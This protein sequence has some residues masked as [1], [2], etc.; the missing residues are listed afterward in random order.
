M[1]GDQRNQAQGGASA[2]L[3]GS[4][5]DVPKARLVCIEAPQLDG[6]LPNGGVVVL[7]PGSEQVIGRDAGCSFAVPSRKLSRQHVRV[8]GGVGTWGVEDLNSTNG[9][10]VN[11]QRVTTAWLKQGDEIRLGP[12]AFRYELEALPAP[13]PS[14]PPEG[15]TVTMTTAMTQQGR[16]VPPPPPA[17]DG[18]ERTMMIGSLSASKAVI[19]A[20]RKSEPKQPP[21]PAAPPVRPRAE[22]VRAPREPMNVKKLIVFGVIGLILAGAGGVAAVYYPK[23]QKQQRMEEVAQAGARVA[24][25]VV[26]RVRDYTGPNTGGENRYDEDV[27]AIRPALDRTWEVLASYPEEAALAEVYARLRFLSFERSFAGVFLKEDFAE[28]QR[29]AQDAQGRLM[30]IERDLPAATDAGQKK[31]LHAAIELLDFANLLVQLREFARKH[32]QVSTTAPNLPTKAEMTAFDEKREQFIKLRRAYNKMLSID[33][34]LFNKIVQDVE[35]R[36]LALI[37]HWREFLTARGGG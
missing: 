28:A 1:S 10:L 20:A 35:N 15:A 22:E 33:Y 11:K 14:G 5:M 32:P 27:A 8:F 19:D 30:G 3:G 4:L 36:D 2:S 13:A 25:I 16:P 37:N 9:V 6:A 21:A 18:G 29:I 12:I 23:Y 17:D 24:R 7:A 26:A 31:E 34:L